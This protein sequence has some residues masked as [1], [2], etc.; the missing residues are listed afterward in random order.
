MSAASSRSLHVGPKPR[1][2]AHDLPG[3]RE[4]LRTEVRAPLAL[5]GARMAGAH[6]G[7]LLAEMDLFFVNQVLN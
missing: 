5:D 7:G 2:A 3:S 6:S 1:C 4:M